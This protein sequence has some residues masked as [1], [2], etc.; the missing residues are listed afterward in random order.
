MGWHALQSRAWS[1][2]QAPRALSSAQ[3]ELYA[4]V[5][6]TSNG[7]GIK[8]IMKDFGRNIGVCILT[9]ANAAFGNRASKR[10]GDECATW[11]L[12]CFG[13]R[14]RSRARRSSTGQPQPGRLADQVPQQ[15]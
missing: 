4:V 2:T 11:T 12:T 5:K 7:I 10:C 13:Y 9:D 1:K 14:T 6:A 3:A 15:H 8:N